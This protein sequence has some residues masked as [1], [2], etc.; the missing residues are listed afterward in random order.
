[1]H[2]T[3]LEW[4][5]YLMGEWPARAYLDDTCILVR[6]E[7]R[8]RHVEEDGLVASYDDFADDA[9]VKIISGDVYWPVTFIEGCDG[10]RRFGLA[11]HFLGWKKV[12]LDRIAREEMERLSAERGRW[13]R[14]VLRSLRAFFTAF[15][16]RPA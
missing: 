12:E 9:E 6:H 16:W 11:E 14:R 4:C 15:N 7:G 13:H 5:R 8:W 2:I 1:L 3:V 10:L